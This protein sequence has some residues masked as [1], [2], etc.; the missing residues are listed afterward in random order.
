MGISDIIA[1]F[2]EELLSE[3][4]G[5]AELQRIDLA[6]RFNCVPS[7]I[8]YVISTRFSPERGYIVESRRGGGGYIRIKRVELEPQILIMHTVNAIG[9]S[10]D[11]STVEAL[12]ANLLQSRVINEAV[13]RLILSAT[14][15]NALRPA[16]IEE[17]NILRASILK[18]MLLNS[19]N[20]L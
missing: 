13:A 15:H 2:I 11:T 5:T 14:G 10:I 3:T 20:I 17:R 16:R 4:G 7:Q 6:N 1:K 8:N 9:E 18:Q 12:I 19:I